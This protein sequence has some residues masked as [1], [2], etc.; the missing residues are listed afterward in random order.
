MRGLILVV[1]L[2]ACYAPTVASDV[3][4]APAGSPQRCPSGQMCIL[5]GGIE[6]C[7]KEG[8]SDIDA[9]IVG[10]DAPQPDG[11]V[12]ANWWDQGWKHRR[13]IDITAGANGAPAGYSISI[14]L[15]HAAL[16]AAGNSIASG[17][18]VRVIRDSDAVQVD[19]VLDTG[20][21]WNTATTKIWFKVSSALAAN[22]TV[23]FWVYYGNLGA[24]TPPQ[25]PMS[26]F[27]YAEDFEGSLAAWSFDMGVGPSTARAHRGTR[28][29]LSPATTAQNRD[30][31]LDPIN[32]SNVVWDLWWNID[33]LTNADM[34][35]YVRGNGTSVFLT[36]LQPPSGGGSS[37]WDIA[38]VVNGQYSEVIP[39]PQGAT[40]PPVDTWFRVTMY[41]YNDQ[42]A[43]DIAGQRYVPSS[44]F[45][46][47]GPTTTGDVGFG[48]YNAVAPAYFDDATLRRFVLPEPTVMLGSTQSL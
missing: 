16:V 30:A 25:N 14:T 41:A 8:G 39:P 34:E 48:I 36:N 22:A 11:Q 45:S 24:G 4:C 6:V 23:R 27:L 18:D 15:D 35:Q 13:A 46:N 40:S 38:K 10:D 1:L 19:R 3:P 21:A 7:S 42:M 5:R 33:D 29:I 31:T 37:T 32:E 17:N 26:A 43:I 47:I 2:G 44:G 28:S 12:P 20:A 9:S